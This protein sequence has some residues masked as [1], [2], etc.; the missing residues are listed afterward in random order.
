MLRYKITILLSKWDQ[1]L[2]IES[3]SLNPIWNPS[4]IIDFGPIQNPRTK[5]SGRSRFWSKFD[6]FQSI[7]DLFRL[8]YWFRDRKSQLKDRKSRF[9]S[10]KSIYFELV[11]QIRPFLIKIDQKI[12]LFNIF[13]SAEIDFVATI[14]IPMTISDPNCWL[15]DN[16][17]PIKNNIWFEV[18]QIALAYILVDGEAEYLR[19]HKIY[20][21]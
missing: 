13:Y 19:N 3:S 17:N 9:L 7:F 5:S 14:W 8:K 4:S 11:D 6:R 18:D 10:K 21:F 20:S 16:S 1:V 15:K 2:R 12:E